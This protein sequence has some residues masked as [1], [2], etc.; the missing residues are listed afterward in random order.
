[1]P[2][3]FNLGLLMRQ[4]IGVGT[5]RGL[6]GRLHAF[7][8]ALSYADSACLEAGSASLAVPTTLFNAQL[9]RDHEI[10]TRPHRRENDS[11]YHD[12]MDSS[13]FRCDM[14]CRIS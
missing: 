1:M 12:G 10:C 8:P 4:L 11:F 9:A 6:Q 14:M 2:A 7:L 5:P 3:A 13:R